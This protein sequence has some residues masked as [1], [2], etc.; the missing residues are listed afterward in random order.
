MQKL[1]NWNA[2]F[3]VIFKHRAGIFPF[4]GCLMR[5]FRRFL[6]IVWVTWKLAMN[7]LK[8]D[9]EEGLI[10]IHECLITNLCCVHGEVS[11]WKVFY[12]RIGWW[13]ENGFTPTR[14]LA[15]FPSYPFSAIIRPSMT[16]PSFGCQCQNYSHVCSKENQ[17]TEWS[18]NKPP[19]WRLRPIKIKKTIE[20]NFSSS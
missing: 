4:V 3:L 6:N 8:I 15:I 20:Y 17:S 5:P 16:H 11:F 1:G 18:K 14:H 7:E 2:T 9:F 19:T 10:C 12:H 13:F